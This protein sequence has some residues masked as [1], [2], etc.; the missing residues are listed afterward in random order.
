MAITIKQLLK[1]IEETNPK[2]DLDLVRL[3]YEY[4]KEAHQDQKRLSGEPYLVHPM[5]TAYQLAELGLDQ[6]TI[7]A[8]LLH[9]IPEDTKFTLADIKKDFGQE[10]T[11]LVKGVTSLGKLKYRGMD[12]YVENLRRMFVAMAKD[13]RVILIR[14]CDRIHNLSTLEY[15]PPEKAKRIALESIE[16]YAKIANRLGMG[17]IKGVIEDLAFPYVYPQEYQWMIKKFKPHYDKMELYSKKMQKGIN[18]LLKDNKIEYF[19][20]HARAKHLYSLY[21]KL[22]HYNKDIQQIYDLVA[23]RIVTDKILDCYQI[24]GLIH[25]QYKPMPGRLKDYIAQPKPNGYQSLHTTVFGGDGQ[26]SEIQIRTKDMHEEAE[27]GIAAHWQYKE[28]GRLS[29]IDRKKYNWVQKILDLQKISD[30]QN[31]YL[32]SL[33]LDIFQNYIF[34]F[35]PKGEVIELPEGATPLDFAYMI[36]SEIGDHCSGAKVNNKIVSLAYP[37][38]SGDV[39]EVFTNAKKKPSLDWLEIAKTDHAKHKIKYFFNRKRN[40]EVKKLTG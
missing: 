11:F 35:T 2:I 19:S 27:Y 31:Q 8:A 26:I 12:R 18:R 5:A 40:K 6:S 23:L 39:V 38:M 36:H 4:A 21:Q 30:D 17:E 33:K 3:A 37:L 28:E 20:I 10:I 25:A 14:I 15:L 9:D 32:K 16:I 7:I 29:E 22:L 24:L 34:V 13:I 1:K